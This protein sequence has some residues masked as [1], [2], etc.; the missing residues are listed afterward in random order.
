MLNVVSRQY[1]VFPYCI[2][3]QFLGSSFLQSSIIISLFHDEGHRPITHDNNT[4]T[5]YAYRYMHGNIQKQTYYTFVCPYR[6][7][8]LKF[9]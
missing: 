6:F 4:C 7:D 3:V 1:N 5:I 2:T 8:L 9:A